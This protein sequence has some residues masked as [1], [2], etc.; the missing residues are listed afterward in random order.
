[1][2]GSADRQTHLWRMLE[3]KWRT[4]KKCDQSLI[5]ACY[6]T[7]WSC[8]AEIHRVNVTADTH[9]FPNRGTCF[10]IKDC[11]KSAVFVRKKIVKLAWLVQF[12][13]RWFS[14]CRMSKLGHKWDLRTAE[15]R[16][17]ECVLRLRY[18]ISWLFQTCLEK[19]RSIIKWE[20]L[21]CRSHVK[22]T[23]GILSDMHCS[24]MLRIYI[25]LGWILY[26]SG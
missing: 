19:S 12:H 9:N 2:G 21:T 26:N 18:P 6:C 14:D 4:F 11:T 7:I 25:I 5:V 16:F 15:T 3:G 23:R 10:S 17:S 13:R 22:S 24:R 8:W 1:M 20:S